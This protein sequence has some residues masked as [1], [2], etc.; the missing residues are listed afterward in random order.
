METK[1][2]AAESKSSKWSLL[3]IDCVSQCNFKQQSSL[4]CFISALYSNI[5]SGKRQFCCHFLAGEYLVRV[6]KRQCCSPSQLCP[7][8][9]ERA[10]GNRL[11]VTLCR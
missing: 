10:R 4:L 8:S 1:K 3:K 6:H 2:S 9:K 7:F 11:D 5:H